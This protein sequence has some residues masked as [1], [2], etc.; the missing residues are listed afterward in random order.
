LSP[1]QIEIR[2]TVREFVSQHIRPA[3]T[4]AAR[5][6][7][8]PP[9]IALAELD[10]ASE[11]GLRSLG[12]AEELG[13][14]GADTLTSCL[15]AEELAAGDVSVAAI[16]SETSALARALFGSA[17]TA[18][19]RN[20]FL[21]R[22]LDD[23]RYHLAYAGHRPGSHMELGVN[24]H[25]PMI[26]PT[27]VEASAVRDSSTG[28]W[29]LNGAK[30]SV[31]NAPFAKLL[32]VSAK[33]DPQASASAGLAVFLVERETAGL[34]IHDSVDGALRQH[35]A[36]GDV[37]LRDCRVPATHLLPAGAAQSIGMALVSMPERQAMNLGVG[38]AAFEAALDYAKLRVQGGSRLIEHQAIGTR[39]A[40]MAIRLEAAR[41]AIWQ[42]AWAADHR[43]AISGRSL[44]DL[45][46]QT[47]AHV[48]TAETVY[49]VAKDAAECFG[50]MGVMRDLPLQK[51]IG[52]ALVFLHAGNGTTDAKLRIAEALAGYERRVATAVAA[53]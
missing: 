7:A 6:E 51:Y 10:K 11:L 34:T 3:A 24:Y 22:F 16:L 21:P 50:A 33:V 28:D 31:G 41:A 18:E 13:G 15:V 42:A 27:L 12:L 49:Q 2:D 52:D 29:I 48:F 4:A 37:V 17:V 38:R 25:R 36:L 1:E 23:A 53:E 9:V 20:R 47:M 19:Q 45:P 30:Q 5:L 44:A 35:G 26:S 43:D 8:A 39:L 46:L 40:D 32:L 14:T